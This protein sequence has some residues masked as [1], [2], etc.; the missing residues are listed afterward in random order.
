MLTGRVAEWRES[1]DSAVR[2]HLIAS[3][4]PAAISYDPA[5]AYEVAVIVRDGLRR[6]DAPDGAPRLQLLSSGTAV[7]WALVGRQ[8][9][10]TVFHPPR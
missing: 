5:F 9:N 8:S 4:N 10:W 2:S 7:H 3:T 6:T 1:L